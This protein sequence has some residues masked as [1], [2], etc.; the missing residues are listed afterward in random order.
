MK[1]HAG[2]ENWNRAA[3]FYVRMQVFVLEREISLQEEFDSK[4][5]DGTVYVVLY[6]D[7][8]PVATGRYK[9]IDSETIRPGRIAVLK[10]YRKQGLG[11]Q[12]LKELEKIGQKNGCT[13][14]VIHG[15]LTAAEFYEKLGY[16]RV[17]DIYYED[18]APCVTLNKQL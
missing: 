12:L 7:G 17:S 6:D 15:E 10:D 2:S 16:V 5:T 8:K 4:D 14:S 18:G 13:K 11:E 3:A 1:V 9:E